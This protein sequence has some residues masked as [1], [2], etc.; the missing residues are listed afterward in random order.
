MFMPAKLRQVLLHPYA[1]FLL[2]ALIPFLYTGFD[3]G[4]AN[5]GWIKLG[6]FLAG[7]SIYNIN[8]TR[9]FGG[10]P[11]DLGMLLGGG[12]F[13]GWQGFLLLFTVLRGVLFYEIVRRLFPEVRAFAVACGLIAIFQPADAVDFWVDVTGVQMALVTALAACLGA[14]VYLQTGRRAALLAMLLFQLFTCLTYSAFLLLMLAFPLG[15]WLLRRAEGLA[16]G[17]LYLLRCC[18]LPIAYVAFQAVLVLLHFGHEGQVADLRPLRILGGYGLE[19]LVFLQNSVEW[20]ADL[21]WAYLPWALPVVALAWFTARSAGAQ[22]RATHTRRWWLLL[23]L[24]L[25]ALAAACYFPYAVSAV[26]LGGRRQLFMAAVFLYMLA[27]LPLFFWLPRKLKLS[28]LPWMFTAAI[29]LVSALVG[30]QHRSYWAETYRGEEKL[31]AGIATLAPQPTSGTYFVV[32]LHSATQARSLGGF[33][34]RR[35]ALEFALRLMYR[36]HSLHAAFTAPAGP[37]FTF[38]PAQLVVRQRLRIN[39]GGNR[40][41]YSQLVVVDFTPDGKIRLLGREWLQRYAPPGIGLKDYD[42]KLRLGAVPSPD[43]KVCVLLE[44]KM[45]P[46]YC[47]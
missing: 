47:R 3:I 38:T 36:D 33:S 27:L 9:V 13:A 45:R 28:W 46:D 16:A 22:E 26:R 10:M 11:R 41:P 1:L 20:I 12:G 18:W 15:A 8:T 29:A 6:G 30:L 42:P 35:T 4:P 23:C 43:S 39:R 40:A 19:S 37:M 21:H 7:G 32:H 14:L 31:L 44:R 2:L 34:N 24:G 25:L 5:D 17:W